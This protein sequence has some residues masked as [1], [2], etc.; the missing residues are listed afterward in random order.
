MK[1]LSSLVIS[2][3]LLLLSINLHAQEAGTVIT[4][5]RITVHEYRSKM[6]AGWIGQMAGVG[7]GGPTEFRYLGRTIPDDEVP[8]WIPEMINVYG[9]DDLYVEMTFLR[10]LEVYGLDVSI[11]QAG[12][13]F[14]NSAYNLWVANKS[15]RDN[16]RNGIPPPNSGHPKYNANADAIDYQIEADYS[17]LISPGLPNTVIALG[18]KFGRM[19]NYG[20]GLYGG[21]FV[22]AMYAEAFFEEDPARIV[23]AGLRAIPAGSQ[24]AKMVRDVMNWYVENP[25]DWK[26][27][28]E[29]VNQKYHENPEYMQFTTPGVGNEFNVDAKLNGAFIVM[30]LLYGQGDIDKTIIISMRCGQDSDC[31]PSNAAGILF[32]MMGYD[33]LPDRFVSGLD[34]EEKFSFTEY[35]FPTLVDVC[36]KLARETVELAGGRVETDPNGNEIFVIPVSKPIPSKLE[37]SWNPGPLSENVF[38]TNELSMIDGHWI[39]RLLLP[40]VFI[41]AFLVLSENRNLKALSVL[42]PLVALFVLLELIK[43]SFAS[44]LLGSMNFITVFETLI[45]G[46]AILLLVGQRI[47]SVN[48]VVS[49]FVAMI[50]LIITGLAGVIGAYDGRY[51]AATEATLDFYAIQAGVWLLAIA[52][53][54]VFCRKKYSRI[55]F[56]L[57]II[58]SSFV[59]N[60]IGIYIY[61]L[62]LAAA[63]AAKTSLAGNIQWLAIGAFVLMIIHYII[64]LPYLI[65]IYRS[66]EYES[67]LLNWIGRGSIKS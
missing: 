18:E 39:Y 56:N 66:I 49:I 55:R 15:G 43:L 31:N 24:Y 33:K 25:D 41:I 35:T 7:W 46:I 23:E 47:K 38:S 9:Q 64:T 51:I 45:S 20:D 27:T 19:M 61:A 5:R 16:L 13:D 54:A 28:W 36:E 8:E 2:T 59:S 62:Q 44:K 37:Q 10:S 4:E 11:N 50:I 57:F 30:G 42:I 40:V 6:K 32:T 26:A 52:L 53:T 12:L 60:L 34:S 1:A 63:N 17:G 29:L 22:G 65:L 3:I 14:A 58:L 21:Q 48:W 67:R